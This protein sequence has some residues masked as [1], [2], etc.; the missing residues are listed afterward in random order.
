MAK[1]GKNNTPKTTYAVF[2][3]I[4]QFKM[5][6]V[7]PMQEGDTI[8]GLADLVTCQEVD[9]FSQRHLGEII[10]DSSCLS[11]EDMLLLFNK[12]NDYLANWT[13]EQKIEWVKRAGLPK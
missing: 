5:T 6:Y 9:D 12:E 7:I 8:E 3:C 2:S 4:S 11:E 10:V 13:D 1:W